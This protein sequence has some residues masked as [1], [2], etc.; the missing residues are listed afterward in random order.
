MLEGD[1]E[2]LLCLDTTL[3]SALPR[4]ANAVKVNE[5]WLRG[6]GRRIIVP[7]LRRSRKFFVAVG[8]GKGRSVSSSSAILKA[9]S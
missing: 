5:A 3:S 1:P 9:T 8:Y 6:S 4:L 7:L 2:I